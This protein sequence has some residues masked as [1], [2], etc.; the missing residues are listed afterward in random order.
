MVCHPGEF[1][2]VRSVEGYRRSLTGVGETYKERKR[3]RT[4]CPICDKNLSVASLPAHLRSKHGIHSTCSIVDD[5][6]LPAPAG[7]K[8]SFP[9]KSRRACPVAGCPYVATTRANLRRHFFYQHPTA[10]LYIKEDGAYRTCDRCGM[11]VSLFSL[12]RGH[13]TS[14]LCDN[15][16]LLAQ[17]RARIAEAV[18]AQA[19]T[20]TLDGDELGKVDTFKYLGRT[21][22]NIDSDWPALQKNLTKARERFARISKVLTWEG[23]TPRI[24]GNFYRAA[25]LSVLLYGSETWVWSKRMVDTVRGFHHKAARLLSGNPPRRLQNGTYWYLPADEAMEACG[26]L[27]I[28]VYIARRW[29]RT[30]DYVQ[31]RPIYDLCANALRAPG[32]PSG[33]VFW[34]EQDLRP[35]LEARPDKD[36]PSLF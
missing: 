33:T 16:V 22:S 9:L 21:V 34:W 7:Y 12:Q 1:R 19:T 23:S 11:S 24:S 28:Q 30:L 26:L 18:E 20:F 29:A 35:W 4:S 17:K 14:T 31:Q 36:A 8:L 6:P 32:T 3:R 25:I 2:G 10:C 15:N 13:Q 27:P 5:G